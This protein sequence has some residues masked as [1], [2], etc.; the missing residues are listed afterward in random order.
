MSFAQRSLRFTNPRRSK[1]HFFTLELGSAFRRIRWQMGLW[2]TMINLT[3]Y[4]WCVVTSKHRNCSILDL[5]N[6]WSVR[7]TCFLCNTACHYNLPSGSID[8]ALFR[9]VTMV[10]ILLH[11]H[12]G[13]HRSVQQSYCNMTS[14]C[15]LCPNLHRVAV[16]SAWSE[17]VKRS[18]PL[19]L[20]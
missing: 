14:T 6:A 16:K 18:S 19:P 8:N 10:P 15:D 12:K 13:F 7:P 20:G 3:L 17:Q 1:K 11:P 5:I 4:A 9:Y 2:I